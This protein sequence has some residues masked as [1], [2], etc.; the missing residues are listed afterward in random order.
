M[1]EHSQTILVNLIQINSPEGGRFS[2][3]DGGTWVDFSSTSDVSW[4][5]SFSFSDTSV[6]LVP[7]K[8]LTHYLIQI[9]G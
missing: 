3:I 9:M 6:L 4:S 7:N 5:I 1:Y 2:V 8:I